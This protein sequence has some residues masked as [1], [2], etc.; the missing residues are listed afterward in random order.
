MRLSTPSD[1]VQLDLT[2]RASSPLLL[3]QQGARRLAGHWRSCCCWGPDPARLI[4]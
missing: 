4:P 1:A 2:L 3:E